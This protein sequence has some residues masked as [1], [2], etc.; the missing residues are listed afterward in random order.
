[1]Y[2]HCTYKRIYCGVGTHDKTVRLT[3]LLHTNEGGLASYPPQ[4]WL[5][6]PSSTP[7]VRGSLLP[8][9]THL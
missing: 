2:V 8:I 7:T 5:K 9:H 1:M 6:I 3:G 4:G